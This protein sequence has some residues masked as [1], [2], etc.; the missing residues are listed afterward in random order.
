[1]SGIY[2][3]IY[4][5][6]DS[7]IANNFQHDSNVNIECTFGFELPGY[8]LHNFIN[9]LCA[10]Q[11]LIAHFNRDQEAYAR[12][13]MGVNNRPY[14]FSIFIRFQETDDYFLRF[15][16]FLMSSLWHLIGII[17]LSALVVLLPFL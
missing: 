14:T 5:C 17:M 1:M 7:R 11:K 3:W 15:L 9:F 16:F 2:E 4:V 10:M 13:Y 12:C 8:G 6:V